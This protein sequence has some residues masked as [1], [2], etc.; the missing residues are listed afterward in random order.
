MRA[1]VENKNK[2]ENLSQL[3]SGL[4]GGLVG[5]STSSAISAAEIG[6]RAVEDNFLS[7]KEIAILDK[8]AEKKVLTPEDVEH[9]TSIK[10]KDK[11]SDALLTKY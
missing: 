8:L 2:S 4:V 10:M 7:E 6:K 3:A 1:V 5:D 11:V 9:I